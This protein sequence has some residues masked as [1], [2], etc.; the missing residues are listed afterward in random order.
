MRHERSGRVEVFYYHKESV[1]TLC[2]R[3]RVLV[4]PGVMTI[5][6][7]DKHSEIQNL[8]TWGRLLSLPLLLLFELMYSRLRKG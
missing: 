2:N 1:A 7:I 5:S 4:L 8:V 3:Y 6:E